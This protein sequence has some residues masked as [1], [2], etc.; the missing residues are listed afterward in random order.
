MLENMQ[1]FQVGSGAMRHATKRHQ[2]LT[3]NIANA[4]TPGYVGKDL[5]NFTLD[6]SK[7]PIG[8][9]ATRE[10]HLNAHEPQDRF[11]RLREAIKN[12]VYEETINGNKVSLEEEVV[13]A[14]ETVGNYNLANAI[15]TKSLS[16]FTFSLGQN[17]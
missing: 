17:R 15:W 4:D 12:P 3:A 10:T 11:S 5:R 2:L 6:T 8:H 7:A 1:I 16:L 13:K 9:K 14:T